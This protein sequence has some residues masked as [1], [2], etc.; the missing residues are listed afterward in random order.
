MENRYNFTQT[1]YDSYINSGANAVILQQMGSDI[2]D[3]AQPQ[4]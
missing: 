3:F 4:P 1:P 2:I